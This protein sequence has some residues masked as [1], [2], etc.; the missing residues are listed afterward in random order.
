MDC[1]LAA[2]SKTSW[3]MTTAGTPAL[4]R[5]IPSRTE[6]EV[7]DPQAQTPTNARSARDNS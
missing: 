1:A 6:P 2:F 7:Q 5:F 4:S 3:E